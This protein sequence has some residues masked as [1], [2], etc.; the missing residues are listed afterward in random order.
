MEWIGCLPVLLN[1]LIHGLAARCLGSAPTLIWKAIISGNKQRYLNAISSGC[2]VNGDGSQNSNRLIA[3]TIKFD[4]ETKRHVKICHLMTSLKMGRARKGT[5]Q[6]TK[7]L[8]SSLSILKIRLGIRTRFICEACKSFCILI[9]WAVLV[10]ELCDGPRVTKKKKGHAKNICLIFLEK[11]TYQIVG[12]D[13]IRHI[14]IFF[15][16]KLT[17]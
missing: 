8:P 10:S 5:L 4:T 13:L 7:L 2:L 1:L 3:I 15:N 14:T 9:L 12:I 17:K 16:L 11:M 6:S